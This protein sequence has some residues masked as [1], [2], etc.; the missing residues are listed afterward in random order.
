MS[1]SFNVLIKK[2]KSKEF[3]K[4]TIAAGAGISVAA[5]LSD[6]RSKDTGLYD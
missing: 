5:G 1:L 6:Y 4:I 3:N 2:L